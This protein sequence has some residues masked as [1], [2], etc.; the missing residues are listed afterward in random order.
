MSFICIFLTANDGEHPVMCSFTV[1]VSSLKIYL[2][3][4]LPTFNKIAFLLSCKSPYILYIPINIYE[5]SFCFLDDV[6]FEAKKKKLTNFD[7]I[8]CNYFFCCDL[9]F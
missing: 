1:S 2:L 6:L 3:K 5:L 7:E 8:Q 4:Y 9:Y